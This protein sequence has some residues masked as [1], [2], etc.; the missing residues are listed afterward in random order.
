MVGVVAWLIAGAC[1]DKP[2][3]KPLKIAEGPVKAEIGWRESPE[4]V[5]RAPI[6]LTGSDGTGLRLVAVEARTVIEDPLAFTE[7][8]LR[9]HNPES[10]RREGR[11]EIVLPPRA[12]VSRFAMRV[13]DGWQEGEVVERR[14]AQQVYE[15]FLHRK[16]DPALLEKAA[17]NEFSARVFPIEP[18]ANKDIILS[19]S[20]ELERHDEPYRIKL[21]GLPKIDTIGIVVRVGS[22]SD[23]GQESS[24]RARTMAGELRLE[25]HDFAPVADVEVRL[26][27]QKQVALRSGTLLVVRVAPQVDA[28]DAPIDGLTVLFDT[29]ASRAHGFG[30]QIERLSGLLAALQ[31]RAGQDIELRVIA[32]DQSSE[33]IY[34]GPSSGFGL[35]DKARLL[36]RDALGASDLQQALTFAAKGG[37]AHARVLLIGDGVVTAGADDSTAL[38][39]A[40]AKLAAH[41]VKRLDALVENGIQDRDLLSVLTRAGLPESGVLL[42]ARAQI[43][44][45]VDALWRGTR[46]RVE[47]KIAGASWVHPQVLEALQPGDERLVFAEL[48]ADAPAQIELVGAGAEAPPSL[49]APEPL[50]ARA[51]ARAKI[52]AMSAELRALAPDAEPRA[53]RERAIVAL[54]LAQRVVSD[55][56]ALLVLETEADYAR[57]GI[58]Q[59][60]LSSILRVGDEGLELFDRRKDGEQRGKLQ[61]AVP[62][63]AQRATDEEA[64]L[65]RHAEQLEGFGGEQPTTEASK[66]MAPAAAAPTDTAPAAERKKQEAPGGLGSLGMSG[67]GAGRR[68]QRGGDAKGAGSL[69]TRARSAPPSAPARVAEPESA[70]PPPAPAPKPASSRA[71]GVDDLL[72]AN[73]EG[74]SNTPGKAD[75]S[76]R[77]MVIAAPLGVEAQAEVRLRIASGLPSAETTQ[78]LRALKPR[79]KQCYERSGATSDARA[80]Q[81]T[82][83]LSVTDKGQVRDA[84]ISGGAL[85][86]PQ[87]RAC[88]LAAARALRF[89][90]PEGANASVDLV[91]TLSSRVVEAPDPLT[92]DP[93]RP[94]PTR[95]RAPVAVAKPTHDDA[96]AVALADVLGALAR[97]DT[98]AA[99]ARATAAHAEDPGDVIALVALGE[100]LEAQ[101]DLERAARAYGSIIDLFPSRP[102]LRRMA[103]ARL[104]RLGEGSVALA[105]DSYRRALEQRP[106]HPSSHRGLAYAQ[107]KQ[108]EHAAAFETL[109]RA[110]ERSFAPDRFEGV[111]RILNEDLALIGAAWMRAEPGAEPRVR[112]ALA[113]RGLSPDKTPSLRFVLSWETDA[114]DVDFHIHDGRGGHAY[115]MKPKLA[116][117]GALYAD[118]TTGY[119]PE[120]FAIPGRARSYPYVLQAHY[121]ARGP[122]G[123]GMGKLQVIDHDGQ[124]GLRF[125]EHPFAIMKDKAFVELARLPAPLAEGS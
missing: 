105:A 16:Q 47:V 92:P 50:L 107:W 70:Q 19:Y 88:V 37:S 95:P 24:D 81:V 93:L 84:Y 48:A 32:F 45:L 17:G 79:A 103:A 109:V 52:E 63:E 86:D 25:A 15:D 51:V 56:T 43:P 91:L 13:G 74:A 68:E 102:D 11:F 49:Q 82:M 87:L 59:S 119:G 64:D 75:R 22:N 71:A 61:V 78:A 42:D 89:P 46:E 57:F 30:A 122:M 35:R 65:A 23:T 44:Q 98:A 125:A 112:E 72:D 2:P 124:G 90:K 116:S 34:E 121:F 83:E 40:V 33:T 77:R 99:L 66:N 117:G 10:R 115:Y 120:C 96:A 113:A 80:L 26:P 31:A 21:Q 100:A 27:W 28:P 3:A 9:F 55:Y 14:R 104:E 12:A 39:E 1:S 8:H 7:L 4:K 41:G 106:D 53:E 111:E 29:S 76:E 18:N 20:E 69:A 60:A 58:E 5:E 38:R 123:Y 110:R 114:N 97:G 94:R 101:K 85:S 62:V 118:I 36:A 67:T 73:A 108:G 6:A 54:S